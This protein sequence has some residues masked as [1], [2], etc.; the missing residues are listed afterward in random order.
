MKQTLQKVLRVLHAT[1]KFQDFT[2][3]G[4]PKVASVEKLLG[5]KVT[6]KQIEKTWFDLFGYSTFRETPDE[7]TQT[8][9]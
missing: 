5:R 6:R 8:K 7:Q 3:S 4:L 2:T 9:A 1:G